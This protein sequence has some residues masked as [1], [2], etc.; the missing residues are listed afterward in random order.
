LALPII[1]FA[2]N[3]TEIKEINLND[4]ISIR[5]KEISESEYFDQ[6]QQSEHLQFEPYEAITDFAETRKLLGGRIKDIDGH[7]YNLEITFNDGSSKKLDE[8]F[9]FNVYYPELNVLIFIYANGDDVPFDLNGSVNASINA[10][11]PHY[12]NFSPDKQF[13]INGIFDGVF[14]T[15]FLEKWDK[16][17]NRYEAV[18]NFGEMQDVYMFRNANELFWINNGKVLMRYKWIGYN[19]EY[20]EMEI[21][22]T[23]NSK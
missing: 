8:Y 4:S 15:Y 2:Q 14:D 6:K 5:I 22:E 16:T 17:K 11:N 23:T 7:L 10:G 1:A 18:G 3:E 13:R 19:T 12:Y 21:I 9:R 20:Y